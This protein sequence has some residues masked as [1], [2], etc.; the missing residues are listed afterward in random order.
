[1]KKTISFYKIL[2]MMPLICLMNA[3][4][5]QDKK[6]AQTAQIKSWIDSSSFIF[7]PQVAMP[8][9]GGTRQLMG[10]FELIVSKDT[11]VSYLPYFGR[12]YN[13]DPASTQSPFDFV[14]TNFDYTVT[15]KKKG[16]WDIIIKIKGTGEAITYSL[17][18]SSN[19]YGSL[20]TTS[21]SRDP[22]SFSGSVVE[23]KRKQQRPSK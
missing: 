1:M 12:A 4:Q 10:D 7:I 19:G 16:G 3:S 9:R 13:V 2:W 8:M 18:I 21:N 11:L 23:R 22:I 20:I 17:S 5:G 14:S 6:T 15:A